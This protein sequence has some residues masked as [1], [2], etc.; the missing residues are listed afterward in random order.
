VGRRGGGREKTYMLGS[1]VKLASDLGSRNTEM[2]HRQKPLC[3]K[4]IDLWNYLL[5]ARFGG[6]G[7]DGLDAG[8][9]GSNP[10]QSMGICSRPSV[11]WCSME[12][13][14]LWRADGVVEMLNWFIIVRVNL[15]WNGPQGLSREADDV[16][17]VCQ[18][19]C[20]INFPNFFRAR[21]LPYPATNVLTIF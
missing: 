6:V 17:S 12:V 7:L 11:L 13:E 8:I 4:E 19:V 16:M 9:V 1:L 2:H 21:E 20:P 14:T 5:A 18:S 15:I 10:V 3:F